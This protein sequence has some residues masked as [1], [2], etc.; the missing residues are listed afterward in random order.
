MESTKWTLNHG[1]HGGA[2]M[3]RD[4][5]TSTFDTEKEARDA[6]QKQ[7]QWYHSIGYVIWF[8]YLTSPDGNKIVLEGGNNAYF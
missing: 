8:A 5:G 4:S 3:S 6:F 2:V 7:K 1:I